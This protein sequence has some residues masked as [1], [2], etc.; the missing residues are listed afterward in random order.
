MSYSHHRH[1]VGKQIANCVLAFVMAF[2]MFACIIL[3]VLKLTVYNCDFMLNVMASMD[4]YSMVRSELK[5]Q[6]QNLGRASGL[7][8]EFAVEYV[9][10]LD[11]IQIEN[12]YISAFYNNEKTLVDTTD[13]KNSFH[14]AI[15]NY[16]EKNNID[17]RTVSEENISYLVNE[18]TQI[19]INNVTLPFFSNI[20]N[21]IE[22]SKTA[23]DITFI[24]LLIAAAGIGCLIFFTNEFKHR[25]Y[26]YL[27]YAFLTTGITTSILPIV[28]FSTNI[29][30]K[31]NF[32][33]RSMYNLFVNYFNSFFSCFWY[34]AIAFIVI[35]FIL[36]LMFLRAYKKAISHSR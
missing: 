18:A 27:C 9:D 31:I 13:F 25:R 19:Y 5:D 20:A 2:V 36:F 24:I 6:F 32:S 23:V 4:Y 14:K 17:K 3:S 21:Y 29:I 22:N 11:L 28:V 15:D 30:S 10:S 1:S 7:S 8:D 33:T 16:I 12:D 26:R 34:F 35:S